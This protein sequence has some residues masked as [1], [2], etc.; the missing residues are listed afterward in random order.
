[1]YEKIKKDHSFSAPCTNCGKNITFA[2]IAKEIRQ[3]A[4]EEVICQSCWDVE[5]YY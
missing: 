4:S 2:E 1:M 3:S 5:E